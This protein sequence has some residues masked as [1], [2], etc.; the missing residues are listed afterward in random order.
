MSIQSVP[1]SDLRYYLVA[2]DKDGHERSD[3]PDG[4]MSDRI[5]AAIHGD[6]ITDAL[7]ISHGWKGDIPGAIEQYDR[8]IKA[9]A[10]CEADL[11]EIRQIRSNFSPLIVGF[12]WPSLPWGDE[13]FGK[14]AR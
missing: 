4:V 6:H 2:F 5:A 7:V 9:M 1:G 8:W 14:G 13:E 11:K 12:H 3:D 10:D